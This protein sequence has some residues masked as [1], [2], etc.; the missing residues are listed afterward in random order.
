M[1]SLVPGGRWWMGALTALICAGCASTPSP[2][3]APLEPPRATFE[4]KIAAI[5]RLEDLRVI[6]DAPAAPPAVTSLVALLTDAEGAVRRR[7]AL[8]VGRAGL[9]AGTEPLSKV[10]ASDGEPE[11]RAMAAFAIGLI[12]DAAGVEA[13]TTA[14]TEPDPRVQGRAAEALGLI[15]EPA[16]ASAGA[17]ARM[18]LTHLSAGALTG[19]DPNEQR[20]PLAAPIEAVRLGVYAMVRLGDVSALRS[21]VLAADGNPSSD[22]WPLAF[23]L[24][25]VR[26]AETLPALR[27]WL[28][29]GGSITRGFAIKGLGELKDA[30]SRP[31]IEAL[32]GDERQPLGVRVQAIRALG[33][34]AEQR[35]ADVLI[36]L[37]PAATPGLL[38]LEATAAIGAMS[39]PAL[40]E[41]LIDYL[42]EP[43]PP[44]RAAAQAAMA[45]S[46][47]DSF[48]PVL[49]GLDNDR[50]WSVRAALA[51]TLGTLSPEAAG[52]RLAQLAS[53][54]DARVI[55]AALRAMTTLKMAGAEKTFI[56]ALA[57]PDVAVR[58]AAAQGLSELKP[59]GA[60]AA[61]VK[62]YEATA[63][64]RGYAVRAALLAA[65]ATMEGPAAA[66]R[67]SAA[68]S[69]PDWAVRVRAAALLREAGTAAQPVRPAPPNAD[70]ALEAVDQMIAPPVSPQAYIRTSRGEFRAELAVLDAPRAVANFISL[71]RRGFF[72]GVRLHR[73]VADFVVQDGDPRGDGEGGPGYAIRD[74]INQRPFLR[75]TL[76]MALDW[77]DT[78]GS[79]WFIAL[80]PQPHLDARYTVFGQVLEGMAAVDALEPW[81]VVEMVRVW[82]GKQWIAG[83]G[84]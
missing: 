62:A 17:I 41:S 71:V 74:E 23:A 19:V 33:A 20:F 76:G 42:E 43:W 8:G 75:G 59:A 81:D 32:A 29:R 14:L 84:K 65:F 22:W 40:A 4:Q 79:Q 64:E 77:K 70:A 9:A 10:L 48:M 67:L 53:D 39:R 44:M 37:L 15:G 72:D 7:A 51:T 68:L 31:A 38:R 73:V 82:D 1:R 16:K 13:L 46:D 2:P 52:P 61:L 18:V 30:A 83:P 60:A 24:Q 78:G 25:R 45:R 63:G 27:I 21:A 35:S 66:P 36:K 26:N 5:L 55:A 28:V 34:I 56:G 69:D 80:S 49:S 54:P 47:A 3:P 6:E 50:D 12:G 57:H 58:I 11:V